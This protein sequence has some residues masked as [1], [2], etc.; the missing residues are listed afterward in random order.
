[1]VK[2]LYGQALETYFRRL[3]FKE[4]T[5]KLIE[6]I[7]SSPPGGDLRGIRG[8]TG[9]WY[10]SRKMSCIIQAESRKIEFSSILELEHSSEYEELD[11]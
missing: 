6:L 1:M 5:Q 11:Y 9:I 10:P 8:D 7:R 3:G 2:P 4:E